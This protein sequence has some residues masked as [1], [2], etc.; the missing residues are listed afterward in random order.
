MKKQVVN[1]SIAQS[2]KV[3]AALYLVI[4]IP[5]VLILA[6]VALASG[7]GASIFFLIFLPLL[8][9]A[10][11][12]LGTAFSAWLYNLVARRVGGLEFTTSEIAER[13]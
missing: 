2:S 1:V 13:V 3:I 7:Q 8:Y 9:A 6:A 10:G 11:A 5:I 4:S 12:F